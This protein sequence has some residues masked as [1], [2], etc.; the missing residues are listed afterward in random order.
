MNL[1]CL[2][3]LKSTIC[4]V[5]L[6][7]LSACC[8]GSTE[9]KV[10]VA[11]FQSQEQHLV[12]RNASTTDENSL[13]KGASSDPDTKHKVSSGTFRLRFRTDLNI[14]LDESDSRRKTATFG[15]SRYTVVY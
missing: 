9:T 5:L 8:L 13:P 6:F 12:R 15:E 3:I 4:V 10:E 2:I 1:S 14:K 11:D 7:Q